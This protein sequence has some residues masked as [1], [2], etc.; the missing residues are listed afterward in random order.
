[1][2]TKPAVKAVKKTAVKAPPSNLI[3][4]L[5][6]VT[7]IN[8]AVFAKSTPAVQTST[9]ADA[10]KAGK[11][12]EVVA[13]F[14]TL[15]NANAI[16]DSLLAGKDVSRELEFNAIKL[17]DADKTALSAVGPILAK[18]AG[19]GPAYPWAEGTP[20][21]MTFTDQRITRGGHWISV[22]AAKALWMRASRYWSNPSLSARAPTEQSIARYDTSESCTKYCTF[23]RDRLN[24]GCQSI[25]RVDVEAIAKH[26]GWAPTIYKPK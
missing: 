19:V 11:P 1:M 6:T 24:I 20:T 2:P 17:T 10:A 26:Y 7:L 16:R 18:I 9:F 4:F 15:Q 8:S 23:R 21:R 14:M 13:D 5:S 12:V 3:R 25:S 22:T